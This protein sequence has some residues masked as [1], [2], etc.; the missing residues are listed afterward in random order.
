MEVCGVILLQFFWISQYLL[1]GI[2]VWNKN[3]A[4][5]MVKVGYEFELNPLN[6]FYGNNNFES[7]KLFYQTHNDH[8]LSIN[9]ENKIIVGSK[10]FFLNN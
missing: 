5:F 3:N 10:E 9:N 4:K 8:E 7:T 6:I 2:H 1:C